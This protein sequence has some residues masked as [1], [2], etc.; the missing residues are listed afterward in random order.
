MVAS[1]A[2]AAAAPLISAKP[3]VASL[4]VQIL[5]TNLQLAK[6]QI[7]ELQQKCADASANVE[8]K[9]TESSCLRSAIERLEQELQES[10]EGAEQLR[11][12]AERLGLQLREA[13]AALHDH[14]AEAEKREQA[15]ADRLMEQGAAAERQVQWW[16]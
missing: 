15:L 11:E 3:F 4:Q 1:I 7:E 9:E 5:S 12:S 6:H 16:R 2:S 8:E 14:K 13:E 10:R